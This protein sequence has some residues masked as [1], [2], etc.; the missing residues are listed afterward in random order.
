M[1]VLPKTVYCEKRVFES[2]LKRSEYIVLN[3]IDVKRYYVICKLL[4]N[5]ILSR[6][7]KTPI[8]MCA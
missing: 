4:S 7:F 6:S 3:P 5:Y 2:F 8:R 1:L